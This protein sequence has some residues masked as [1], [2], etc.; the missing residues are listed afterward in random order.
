MINTCDEV[1]FYLNNSFTDTCNFTRNAPCLST[2]V[3]T[4]TARL[5]GKS[6]TFLKIFRGETYNHFKNI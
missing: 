1:P 2:A 3:G 6:V 5:T 4:A